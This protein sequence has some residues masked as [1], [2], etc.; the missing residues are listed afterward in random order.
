MPYSILLSKSSRAAIGLSLKESL[1]LIDEAH[2]LPEAIRAIHSCKLNL[3]VTEAAL[4]QLS[5]YTQQYSSRLAGRNLYYLGQIR[6]CLTALIKYLSLDPTNASREM[7]SS[8]ELLIALKI[9]NVNI[10]KIIRYLDASRLPQKLLGFT[11]NRLASSAESAF[12]SGEQGFSKHISALSIA[13]SFL[14]KLTSSPKE[15]KFVIDWPTQGPGDTRSKASRRPTHP[16]LRFVL[17]HPAAHF[18]T[19]LQDAHGVALVGGTL[20]PFAH[21][22][23]ELLGNKHIEAAA[24]ADCEL[25][26]C[27]ESVLNTFSPALTTFTCDHVVSSS[28]VR[29]ECLATGPTNEKL[30]FRHMSRTTNHVC[31]ELGRVILVICKKVP[32][33]VVLFLP[34]YSYEAHL[35]R[36]WKESGIWQDLMRVKNIHREP[37]TSQQV[38]AVLNAYSRDAYSS[39]AMLLSVV[40]GK[41]SEGI[42]FADDMARCVIVVGLPYPDITDPELKEKMTSIDQNAT[43]VNGTITGQT[44]YHNL[45]MRAVNQSVGRAIRHANDY[46]AIILIDVRYTSDKRVW[47][48]LPSWLRRDA[49]QSSQSFKSFEEN[50]ASFFQLRQSLSVDAS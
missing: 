19:V 49:C 11:S 45:C 17:L 13:Q 33:G 7:L 44:Y 23:A 48:S 5:A 36:R 41:M 35:V 6:K 18:Q 31:D 12:A 38:E 10:F 1:V 37:T 30:D 39:G 43:K 26:S 25:K 46:A 29:L 32:S 20:K 47:N 24:N 21:I 40:G 4:E 27:T 9:D 22:A 34:S 28:N 16:T 14:E 50:L 42:N 2:N 8:G 3:P 15:G